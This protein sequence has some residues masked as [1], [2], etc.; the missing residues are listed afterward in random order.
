M[1]NVLERWSQKLFVGPRLNPLHVLLRVRFHAPLRVPP[2]FSS[3]HRGFVLKSRLVV[4]FS[5]LSSIGPLMTLYQY[6]IKECQTTTNALIVLSVGHCSILSFL[7][8]LAKELHNLRLPS[9][10]TMH[11]GILNVVPASCMPYIAKA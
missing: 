1:E 5:F 7:R 4:P 8:A 6:A 2:P 11:T 9:L 3:A 10:A